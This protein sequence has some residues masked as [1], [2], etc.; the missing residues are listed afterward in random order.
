MFKCNSLRTCMMIP[1]MTNCVIFVPNHHELESPWT[2]GY[3]R[4]SPLSTLVS[5]SCHCHHHPEQGPPQPSS[6]NTHED[7][8]CL[9]TSKS[10]Q[11]WSQPSYKFMKISSDWW[12]INNFSASKGTRK[13]GWKQLSSMWS[14][15]LTD[16]SSPWEPDSSSSLDK[17][18]SL[19]SLFFIISCNQITSI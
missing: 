12:F 14:V 7:R 11:C 1:N 9:L 8:P 13:A 18:L 4:L 6:P 3:R 5:K 16:R 2:W 17:T 19:V 10:R 15:Q